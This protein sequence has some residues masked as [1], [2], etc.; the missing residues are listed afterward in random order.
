MK[1][2]SKMSKNNS[3]SRND[4]K[5]NSRLDNSSSNYDDSDSTAGKEQDKSIRSKLQLAS[6]T[7]ST[8]TASTLPLKFQKNQVT[9]ECIVEDDHLME[10][11]E[12][13]MKTEE[14][15][16]PEEVDESV[17]EG[18]VTV[19]PQASIVAQLSGWVS[20]KMS[21]KKISNNSVFPDEVSAI[22]QKR[23]FVGPFPNNVSS[24]AFMENTD[25][26]TGQNKENQMMSGAFHQQIEKVVSPLPSSITSFQ[27]KDNGEDEQ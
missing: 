8:D 18:E 10:K 24:R 2:R 12:E 26:E 16:E 25:I 9:P 22:S 4:S 15:E 20:A 6:S 27:S 23:S 11:E 5:N 3:R 13:V 14:T 19:L 17:P 1:K 21:S 7:H